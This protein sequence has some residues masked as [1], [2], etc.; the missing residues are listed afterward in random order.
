MIS[1]FNG[2]KWRQGLGQE[3]GA[4]I[5]EGVVA[6]A[7]RQQRAA[8]RLHVHRDLFRLL[9]TEADRALEDGVRL[10]ADRLGR[11][12]KRVAALEIRR[13][14][15]VGLDQ[16]EGDRRC[17]LRQV[18]NLHRLAHDFRADTVS[19]QQRD[20]VVL[21]TVVSGFRFVGHRDCHRY[22]KGGHST[23]DALKFHRFE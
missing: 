18:E 3:H 6:P 7:Q 4:E 16:V 14:A 2:E 23:V 5:G 22:T 17:A 19:G 10:V 15:E 1:G 12:G 8:L 20:L 13:G 11:V 9:V 21:H